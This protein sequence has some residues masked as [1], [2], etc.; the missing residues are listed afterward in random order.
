M[1]IGQ[2]KTDLDAIGTE[3]DSAAFLAIDAEVE[4]MQARL[5]SQPSHIKEQFTHYF[6]QNSA[7]DQQEYESDGSASDP[8]DT[9]ELDTEDQ[10]APLY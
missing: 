5:C 2:H 4:S 10:N 3:L 6:N 9:Q 1:Q 8:D 7:Q